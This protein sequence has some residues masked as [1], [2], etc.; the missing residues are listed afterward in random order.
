MR[1]EGKFAVI[2]C[3]KTDV[4][5]ETLPEALVQLVERCIAVQS[6]ESGV[7]AIKSKRLRVFFAEKRVNQR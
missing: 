7:I 3:K 6:C 4:S 2:F 1:K 5:R